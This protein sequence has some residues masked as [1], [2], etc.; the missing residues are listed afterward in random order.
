[1]SGRLSGFQPSLPPPCSR[2]IPT[3]PA[4]VRIPGPPSHP[5]FP[6]ETPYPSDELPRTWWLAPV[7]PVC[8]QAAVAARPGLTRRCDCR[9]AAPGGAMDSSL[10]RTTQEAAMSR[11]AGE[12]EAELETEYEDEL[13]DEWEGEDEGEEFLGALGGIARTVGGLLGQGEREEEGE[14]EAEEFFKSIGRAF[15]KAAPFLRTLAKT[16]GPLVATAVG[17]PAAGALARAVASQ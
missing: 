8:G 12:L 14:D 5:G 15:R 6:A 10:R 3:R 4:Q 16:A 2:T 1:M 9:P 13:E 11:L 7:S 17:G